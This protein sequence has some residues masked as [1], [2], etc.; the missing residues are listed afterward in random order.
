[1]VLIIFKYE[2]FRYIGDPPETIRY[3]SLDTC[4]F[5]EWLISGAESLL[6]Q[7]KTKLISFMRTFESPWINMN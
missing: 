1:M 2:I 6:T 7:N 5:F 3:G 4:A